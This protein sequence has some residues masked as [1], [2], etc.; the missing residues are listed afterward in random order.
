L[1]LQDWSKAKHV[2]LERNPDYWGKPYYFSRAVY[3]YIQ[4]PETVRQQVLQGDLDWAGIPEKDL[5]LKAKS[6]PNVV[7]GKVIPLEYVYPAY[8]YIGYNLKREFFKDK[9]V[10]LALA[11]AVQVDE[12][13]KNVLKG[14]ATRTTGISLRNSPNYDSTLPEIPYD[15]DKARQLLSEAG[16][17]DSD[18]DGLRDKTIG[19]KKFVA[20]FDLLIY[21]ASPTF[22]TIAEVIKEDC[23]KI[24]V[25][26]LV[27]RSEWNFM[28]QK[29][30]KKDFDAAMLGWALSWKLD[31]LQIF[32]SSQADVPDSSN[33]IS[34]RNPEVD[35]LIEELRMTVDVKRQ[36]EIYLQLHRL[37][38]DDQPY[39]FLFSE[40]RT[41]FYNGRLKNVKTYDLKPCV[42]DS[43]WTST[44]PRNNL[45]K[46]IGK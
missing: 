44:R 13:I 12:L 45:S 18:G 42:D 30:R 6:H 1:M 40:L 10:R 19:G 34:Y 46:A 27:T 43:E 35:K 38:Y 39:T 32:H 3:E 28:L 26:V 29:L 4:N 8:R 23:R 37:I 7:A 33:S 21:N 16:W 24:G 11:H 22:T 31:P 36:R 20:R 41:G 17:E 5:Y 25:E 14:L 15:L 2:I 9:R